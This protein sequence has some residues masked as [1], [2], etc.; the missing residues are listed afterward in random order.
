LQVRE[1]Q[2]A[3]FNYILVVGAQE[4]ETGN[5]CVRVRDSANLS[6]MSVDGIITRLREEIAAFK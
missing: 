5:V 4:A 6:T 2:I 3:Q 1:A